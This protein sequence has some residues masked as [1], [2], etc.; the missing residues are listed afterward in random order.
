[1]WLMCRYKK[2]LVCFIIT[3]SIWTADLIQGHGL[4]E[5]LWFEVL[6]PENVAYTYKIRSARDFGEIISTPLHRVNLVPVEPSEAC[7]HVIDNGHLLQNQVALVTRGGCSFVTKVLNV[8][9]YGAAA[10]IISDYDADSVTLWIDMVDDGTNR[11]RDVEIPAFYM[12]GKDGK[13][14]RDAI[15]SRNTVAAVINLPVNHTTVSTSYINQP[16]W[17]HW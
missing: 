12:L 4:N 5:Q 14:I 15:K 9:S 7:G 6:F 11:G 16:P 3:F 1:M 2:L 10:V 13:M 8:E 17:D